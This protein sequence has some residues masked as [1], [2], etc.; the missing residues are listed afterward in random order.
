[1]ASVLFV[2]SI[3]VFAQALPAAAPESVGLSSE[4]LGRVDE[5]FESY[6]ADGRMAG[7]V[8][9]IARHGKLAHFRTLGRMDMTQDE[10]MRANAIFRMASMTK[11][12]TSTAIMILYEEGHFQLED[13]VARYIPELSG[14]KPETSNVEGVEAREMSIRDLLIHTAGLPGNGQDPRHNR[15]WTNLDLTLQ[16][17]MA[18][19]GKQPLAYSPGTDWRYS[20]ATNILGYLIEVVSQQSIDVFFEERIL[21]P[22]GMLDTRFFVPEAESDRLPA[23]YGVSEDGVTE[24]LW[25]EPLERELRLPKAPRGTGG[26]FSTANDYLRFAQ[27][28]LNGGELDGVRLL[29]PK[30]VE[31][32]TTDHLPAGVSIS[33]P[34]LAGY[35]WGLGVRVRTDLAESQFLGS[36]GEYGWVGAFGTFFLVDPRE[37]L[38]AMFL[39]QLRNSASFP[40]R[41]QFNNAVYQAIVE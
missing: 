29:S 26:L 20:E 19:A 35:G 28:L 38:V 37:S 11:P 2:V 17:Q 12:I 4:R 13:P 40:I 10:P 16:Q 24:E 25:S 6:I 8:V 32:M 1:M 34:S 27:M 23:V 14:M 9:A 39:P 5:L 18:E 30:T 41:R 21:R 31:L 7:V 36:V 3:N 15:V 33:D 22:L